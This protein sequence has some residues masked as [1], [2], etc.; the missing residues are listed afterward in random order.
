MEVIA[1]FPARPSVAGSACQKPEAVAAP[2]QRRKVDPVP[3][4]S[5]VALAL[6]AAIVWSVALHKESLVE[7]SVESSGFRGGTVMHEVARQ[8]A[9][10]ASR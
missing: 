4:W 2:P 10:G 6:V 8:P 5:I 7:S 3:T 9:P 1:R